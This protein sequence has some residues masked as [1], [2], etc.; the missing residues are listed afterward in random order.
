MM[1]KVWNNTEGTGAP[2][3][4]RLFAYDGWNLIATL[5]SQLSTLNSFAWGLDL[6]GSLQGAGGVGG[7]LWVNDTSTINSQ[8]STH[9]VSF[10]GNG[11]VV[12]L[13]NAADGAESAAYEYGP[14]SEPIRV[15]GPVASLMPLRFST[16]YEDNVTG[17]RKYLFRDCTPST[18]RWKSRDPIGE[19]IGGV[20]LY[21]FCAADSL[22]RT[23]DLGLAFYAIGGTWEVADDGANAWQLYND[24]TERPKYYWAGPQ[25][26]WG[27]AFGKGSLDIAL[28][29]YD[30]I[31]IDFCA[32]KAKGQELTIN[33]TGWSRG[34]MIA[35]YIARRLNEFGLACKTCHGFE[36]H[37]GVKVNWVG[38]FDAVS[39]MEN[40][41]F[42][43]TVPPNVAHFDHAIKTKHDGKQSIF[44]T[45]HFSGSNEEEFMNNDGSRTMHDDIGMSVILKRDNNVYPWMRQQAI[46]AGVG[47]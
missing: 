16:M 26:P 31:E 23:D 17:D 12:A 9:L 45:W 39:M 2:S 29:V 22:N 24:T 46:T 37:Y 20:S 28:K 41:G 14:F 34:A 15:T 36:F 30:Q 33:L 44:P 7:L 18:G 8:P 11:N 38:L 5:N 32:A 47:F 21:G 40:I 4:D 10:D 25:G 27:G 1:K 35:S 6:S 3:V 19:G 43:T 13:H 42:P